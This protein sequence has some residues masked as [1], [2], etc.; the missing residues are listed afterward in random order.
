MVYTLRVLSVF[1]MLSAFLNVRTVPAM[2]P[3]YSG[4][5][6][7]SRLL[8]STMSVAIQQC[9]TRPTAVSDR[10]HICRPTECRMMSLLD[11]CSP[12][13][14]LLYIA[15]VSADKHTNW[16]RWDS[17]SCI[18]VGAIEH[19]ATLMNAVVC[20][21]RLRRRPKVRS[22][23]R[24]YVFIRARQD[25]TQRRR[26]GSSRIRIGWNDFSRVRSS[27]VVVKLNSA[28]SCRAH[29]TYQH[30]VSRPAVE[31]ENSVRSVWNDPFP[32]SHTNAHHAIT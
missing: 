19:R 2:K 27:S 15:A 4:R 16:P 14:R 1:G 31:C 30:A 21:T 18:T 8:S 9:W 11:T 3:A 5:Y 26:R 12:C 23:F 24:M 22:W 10:R 25:C 29:V 28:R 17:I 13:R 6:Y 20:G 7:D 32:V